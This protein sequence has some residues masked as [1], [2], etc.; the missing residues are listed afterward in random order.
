MEENRNKPPAFARYRREAE[1]EH[2]PERQASHPPAEAPRQPEPARPAPSHDHD[3]PARGLGAVRPRHADEGRPA[4]PAAPAGE[5]RA[6]PR[7]AGPGRR[8]VDPTLSPHDARPPVG[9]REAGAGFA[10]APAMRRPGTAAAESPLGRPQTQNNI[11]TRGA[12][13]RAAAAEAAA[14]ERAPA[15]MPG[16]IWGDSQLRRPSAPE[17][18]RDRADPGPRAAAGSTGVRHIVAEDR[19]Q[20][21]ISRKAMIV[22]VLAI[23]VFG[24]FGSV[25]YLAWRQTL[26]FSS[27]IPLIKASDKPYKEPP[28]AGGGTDVADSSSN[29]MGVFTRQNDNARV[30]RIMP[31]GEPQP[32]SLDQADPGLRARTDTP[33]EQEQAAQPAAPVEPAKKPVESQPAQKLATLE[34]PPLGAIPSVPAA[35]TAS[36]PVRTEQPTRSE[37]PARQAQPPREAVVP[38]AATRTTP[39]AATPAPTVQSTASRP[40]PSPAPQ[41]VPSSAGGP[42]SLFPSNGSEPRQDTQVAAVPRPAA[43]AAAPA[44]SSSGSGGGSWRVQV[45]AVGSR[46]AAEDAWRNIRS[47]NPSIAALPVNFITAQVGSVQVV[48]VQ[49][50]SFADRD[51]AARICQ[52]MRATGSDCFVVGASR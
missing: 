51:A 11:F 21:I 5:R 28:E 38:P 14:A 29:I 50:G 32:M 42:R 40:T 35:P 6:E 46:A 3:G 13:I 16:P 19:Q 30:E 20:P 24:L 39:P 2:A 18:E 1:A 34:A 9:A 36:T 31:R 45:A 43:P 37:T 44:A 47:R 49:A 12:Q 52:S 41:P 25:I 48:R 17:V 15:T 7:E 8:D 27:D 26:G 22:G 23:L 4:R 33:P 10:G